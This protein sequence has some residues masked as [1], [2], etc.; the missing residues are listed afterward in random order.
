MEQGHVKDTGVGSYFKEHQV[1]EVKIRRLSSVT[2]KGTI[3]FC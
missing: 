1:V 2:T 3:Q